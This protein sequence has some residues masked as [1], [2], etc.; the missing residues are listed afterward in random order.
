MGV[1]P[2]TPL[3]IVKDSKQNR[4]RLPTDRFYLEMW[5]RFDKTIFPDI[6]G[7]EKGDS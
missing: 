1:C 7:E 5:N 4:N 3:T 2:A 6:L